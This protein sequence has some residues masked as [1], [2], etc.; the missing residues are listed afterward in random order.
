MDST[1]SNEQ[2]V[3][4]SIPIEGV[5]PA[6]IINYVA[7][8]KESVVL[9]DAA[10]EIPNP[11]SQIQNLNA[12]YLLEN[13]PKSV[14]C[15]PLLN[16]GKLTGILYLENNL[17]AGAF[18]P[19]RLEVLKLL[20]GQAAISIENAKLYS[21]LRE[22]ESRLAQFLE[23][24]PVGV[25][26][27]DATGKPLYSNRT[28]QQLVGKGVVADAQIEQLAEIYQLYIAGTSQLYP[29]DQQPIVRALRGESTSVDDMEIHLPDKIVPVEVWGTP[30]YDAQG[31]IAYGIVA[32]QDITERKRA[33]AERERFT[34]E[35]FQL[36]KA[37]ERFVPRKFLEFCK[38]KAL[39][40]SSWATK[41]S[42]R[43]RCC[44]PTFATSPP[45]P[46]A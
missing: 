20:S 37:Y 38:R 19:D 30:I 33:E 3:L 40:M 43:C 36:N 22:S 44:F 9:D 6:A 35:L 26:V 34:S 5:L 31:N 32:F 10:G 23:A 17:T 1:G 39:S 21:E 14:L 29:V 28:A 16:Q 18:T 45:S 13:K 27:L 24:V 12:P 2:A 4:Q 8:T 42:R 7:R 41:C 11:K 46:K 25:A 15:A